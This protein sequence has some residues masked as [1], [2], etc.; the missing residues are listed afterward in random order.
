MCDWFRLDKRSKVK[1]MSEKTEERT[2]KVK[3]TKCLSSCHFKSVTF[4]NTFSGMLC[5]KKGTW[6]DNMR[7]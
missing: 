6:E 7:K 4:T 2:G 3:D 5:L 1:R